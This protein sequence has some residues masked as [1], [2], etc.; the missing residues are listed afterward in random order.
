[1]TAVGDISQ[2]VRSR[3]ARA[4]FLNELE[5]VLQDIRTAVWSGVSRGRY[6]PLPGV[7]FGAWVQGI[8]NHVCAAHITK[9]A[10]H[11]AVPLFTAESDEHPS[12][13]RPQDVVA[14][15][16]GIADQEWTRNV[17]KL[18][19][20]CA[21]E[22]AWGSAMFLLVDDCDDGQGVAS[23]AADRVDAL[24]YRRAQRDLKF[25]RQVAV[26]V[27]NALALVESDQANA[28][29]IAL[30]ASKCLPTELH[31][32]IAATIVVPGLRGPERLAALPVIAA[33]INVTPRYVAVQT[34]RARALYRA[35]LEVIRMSQ[36]P[37]AM[38]S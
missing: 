38:P 37:Q 30:D 34:G 22:E 14:E 17:L 9:A 16:D 7:R 5:D 1:M 35:A 26:T 2:F 28:D 25:V 31:R 20:M 36:P 8:A 10:A 32:A 23:A 12:V 4:G 15:P 6:Q 3:L 13:D 21:G 24:V 11:Y 27:R 19:R 29:T 18:T 33:K